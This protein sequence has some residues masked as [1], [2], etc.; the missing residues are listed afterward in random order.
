MFM[1]SPIPAS[2]TLDFDQISPRNAK[3][4][5]PET[6]KN[7]CGRR[8]TVELPE[9]GECTPPP[10]NFSPGGTPGGTPGGQTEKWSEMASQRSKKAEIKAIRCRISRGI[11]IR[12]LK[13]RIPAKK[14]PKSRKTFTEVQKF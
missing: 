13:P 1:L 5:T 11:R 6:Y 4:G 3:K 7:Q 10:A 14:G 2:K 9:G 8:K 12:A